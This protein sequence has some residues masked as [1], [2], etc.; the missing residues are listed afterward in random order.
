MLSDAN[1]EPSQNPHGRGEQK[2]ASKTA[3]A[4]LTACLPMGCGRLEHRWHLL[5]PTSCFQP[6]QSDGAG[7]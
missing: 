5:R 7:W 4:A 2:A 3:I 6:R 1:G